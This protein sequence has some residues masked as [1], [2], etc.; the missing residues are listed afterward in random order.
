L[1]EFPLEDPQVL[2]DSMSAPL[3]CGPGGSGTFFPLIQSEYTWNNYLR[4]TL[5]GAAMMYLFLG[6]NIVADKFVSSI[7]TITSKKKRTW[8]KALGRMVTVTTWNATVANL[9]LMALGSSAPEIL[10]SVAEIMMGGFFSGEIGP[11]TI[12]GSAAFNLF[13][14]VAVCIATIPSPEIRKIKEYDVFIV[15]AVF[16]LFA[17]LW[18]VFIVQV[19]SPDVVEV[20]E[21]IVTLLLFPVLIVISYLADVGKLPGMGG[22][23]ASVPRL[24]LDGSRGRG[25]DLQE[26]PSSLRSA[27]P[28]LRR[29]RSWPPSA[30]T[31]VAPPTATVDSDLGTGVRLDDPV[32]DR[33]GRTIRNSA[34]VITFESDTIS[35]YG[36]MEE[37]ITRVT[38]MRVNGSEGTVTCKYRMEKLSAVPGYDFDDPAEDEGVLE[39]PPGVT[40]AE[41]PF[42]VLRKQLGEHSDQFQIILEDVEG[43]AIFNPNSDGGEEQNVLTVTILNESEVITQHSLLMKANRFMDGVMNYDELRLSSST[44]WDEVMD[45]IINVSGDDDSQPS[46]SDWVMHIISFPWKFAFAILIPP[47]VLAGGWACFV[48][49]IGFIGFLTIIVIDFAELFGCVTGVEDSIT[50]ITIVALGTSMPDLFASMTAAAQDPF[51]DASIVNVTGSNSVNVFLGIGLPW[52]FASIYWAVNGANNKWKELY[53]D[54]LPQYPNGAFI[55]KG[56][57]LGFSVIVF[58]VAACVCLGVIRLRRTKFGGELGG[59][60]VPKVL[61]S[62]L[63]AMLWVYYLA[64]SIW[65]VKAQGASIGM[66]ILAIF[67]G[68][69]VL[70]N[71]MM[72]AGVG[73]WLL[74]GFKTKTQ[75][76]VDPEAAVDASLYP[77]HTTHAKPDT[78]LRGAT[79]VVHG[80]PLAMYPTIDT[81]DR[82]LREVAHIGGLEESCGTPRFASETQRMSLSTAATV[83]LA[84]GKLLRSMRKNSQPPLLSCEPVQG[85]AQPLR[86]LANSTAMSGPVV[87]GYAIGSIQQPQR[88]NF[89]P[90]SESFH[91]LPDA[92]LT[93]QRTPA[94]PAR[95][96]PGPLDPAAG[97][98]SQDGSIGWVAGRAVELGAMLVAGL[99]ATQLA[100]RPRHT[101]F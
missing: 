34:G 92:N 28:Q 81:R 58:T 24:H 15:T 42:K 87:H 30:G 6:V 10:L 20:W 2:L 96:R 49:S 90:R 70:E 63:L 3:I 68:L 78:I 59:P 73:V 11:S 1:R 80:R 56:G 77:E 23:P 55:V 50:A 13:V 53:R 57:D 66:Q 85:T 21:A 67:I 98:S 14:I 37:R 51:A 69:I 47:P 99:A 35:V 61:S 26:E 93:P 86:N 52:S 89:L 31:A 72:V 22:K 84:R 64:L 88:P 71:V 79:P 76:E 32:K 97:S 7:E 60:F 40:C 39:F 27:V 82:H 45:S 41:I 75:E 4:A 18:L 5:Y 95:P 83:A 25:S 54:F 36:G 16:S 33:H 101:Q 43:G 12:V 46:L 100:D 94:T 17:Y 62:T 44:W 38:V 29:I 8:S 9:T 91:S 19:A 48:I 74:G 65:K